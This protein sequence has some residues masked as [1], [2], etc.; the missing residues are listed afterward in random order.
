MPWMLWVCHLVAAKRSLPEFDDPPHRCICTG[1]LVHL[2]SESGKQRAVLLELLGRIAEPNAT[3]DL[4]TDEVVAKA[5][6]R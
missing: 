6:G 4:A 5:L 2:R 1:H 3:D